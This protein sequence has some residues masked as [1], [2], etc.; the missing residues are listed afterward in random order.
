MLY[1]FLLCPCHV[2]TSNEKTEKR[3][4]ILKHPREPVSLN[5]WERFVPA[6]NALGKDSMVP[7]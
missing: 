3:N 6:Y 2:Q 1:M 5:V 4:P 7:T